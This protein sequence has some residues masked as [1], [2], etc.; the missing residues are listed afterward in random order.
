MTVDWCC[1][2]A[3]WHAYCIAFVGSLSDH[4]AAPR[5][6]ALRRLANSTAIKDGDAL[7]IDVLMLRSNHVVQI[8]FSSFP[9]VKTVP[10]TFLLGNSHLHHW[11]SRDTFADSICTAG[12]KMASAMEIL[13]GKYRLHLHKRPIKCI[14]MLFT[15]HAKAEYTVEYN[16]VVDVKH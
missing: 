6:R 15:V 4:W 7:R 5:T 11:R 14:R 1:H 10:I 3:D 8:V 12:K 9:V 13:H 2:I 16:I